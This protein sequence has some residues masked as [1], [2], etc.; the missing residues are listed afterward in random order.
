TRLPARR[1]TAK[2]ST[3]QGFRFWRCSRYPYL[4]FYV[5]FEDRLEVWRVLQDQRDIA[6]WL[7]SSGE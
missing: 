2:N 6:R 4:V 7:Q 5:E 3:V 1:A